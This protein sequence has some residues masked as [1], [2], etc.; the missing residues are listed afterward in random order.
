MIETNDKN[1]LK[2]KRWIHLF[3]PLF[4]GNFIRPQYIMYLLYMLFSE[5]EKNGIFQEII[6][7]P[8]S[9][10]ITIIGNSLEPTSM[11]L[12]EEIENTIKSTLKIFKPEIAENFFRFELSYLSNKELNYV[13]DDQYPDKY[14]Y[15]RYIYSLQNPY[16]NFN[17]QN[18]IYDEKPKIREGYVQ[19]KLTN[20]II[21]YNLA[22]ENYVEDNY[23]KLSI[24]HLYNLLINPPTKTKTKTKA[25]KDYLK[26]MP[27]PTD[28]YRY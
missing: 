1:E 14:I 4:Q 10:K 27:D 20:M 11:S 2:N 24:N 19:Q 9:I 15:I 25:K 6:A 22:V 7:S 17:I 13:E 21:V 8:L 28:W 16:T 23:K 26:D 5:N 12:R 3:C 18:F